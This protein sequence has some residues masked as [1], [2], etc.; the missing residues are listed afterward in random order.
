VKTFFFALGA[1]ALVGCGTFKPVGV[2]SKETSITQQSQPMPTAGDP[3][4]RPPAVRPTP[5][6][7]TVTPGDVDPGNPYITA[8]KLSLEIAT[9]IQSTVNLPVTVETSRYKDGVR[10]P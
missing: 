1:L 5:P 6:T 8:N 7:M 9:D 10:Q 4:A 2:L 3:G